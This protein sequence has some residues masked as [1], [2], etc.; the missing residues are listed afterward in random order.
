MP[1]A[2]H[3]SQLGTPILQSSAGHIQQYLQSPISAYNRQSLGADITKI[4]ANKY[5][6]H[7]I[8]LSA[9]FGFFYSKGLIRLTAK[10]SSRSVLSTSSCKSVTL[11]E[12]HDA[13]NHRQ[14]DCLF[15][16]LFR[17]TSMKMSKLPVDSP[18]KGP[19]MRRAFT[20]HDA[21]SKSWDAHRVIHAHI[22][23]LEAGV[24]PVSQL[25]EL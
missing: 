18:H 10:T 6:K 19:V 17:L 21:I 7:V 22:T 9:T 5:I 13:W 14:L 11:S 12:R 25:K 8:I 24:V 20:S 2:V 1:P 3:V 4:V 23:A 16:I 15:H